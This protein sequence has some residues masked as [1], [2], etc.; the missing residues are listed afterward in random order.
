MKIAQRETAINC[1][2]GRIITIL[3]P[4]QNQQVIYVIKSGKDYSLSELVR[5]T[6][7][8]KSSI[9]RCVNSLR[10]AGLLVTAPERKCSISGIR[11]LPSK[12]PAKQVELFQ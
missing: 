2:Y 3:A 9:S 11:I 7:I 1:Y 6:G 4:T 10:A 8:E 12:L 5:L